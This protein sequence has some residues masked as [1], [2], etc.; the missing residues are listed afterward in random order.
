M[1]AGMGGW[2]APLKKMFKATM[3]MRHLHTH[4]S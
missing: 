2:D 4:G 3:A 1:I